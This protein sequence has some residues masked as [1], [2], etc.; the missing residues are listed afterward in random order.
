MH[1]ERKFISGQIL[2]TKTFLKGWQSSGGMNNAII[3]MRNNMERCIPLFGFSEF[4]VEGMYMDM[5]TNFY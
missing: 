4:I 1:G 3:D 2:I 5:I